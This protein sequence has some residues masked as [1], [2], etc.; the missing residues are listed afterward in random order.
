VR[1]LR[2]CVELPVIAVGADFV[3]PVIAVGAGFVATM[4]GAY[5]RRQLKMPESGW[6]V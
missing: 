1:D 6:L 5:D 4:A 2:D 3:V